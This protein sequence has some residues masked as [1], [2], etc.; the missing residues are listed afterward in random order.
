MIPPWVAGLYFRPRS[1]ER[2]PA[3]RRL[4]YHVPISD[5]SGPS[6]SWY[7]M[8]VLSVL[9][10]LR[11]KWRRKRPGDAWRW[12]KVW[13][14]AYSLAYSILYDHACAEEVADE[15]LLSYAGKL[16]RVRHRGRNRHSYAKR[17]GD[18]GRQTTFRK[19]QLPEHLE[20]AASVFHFS[21]A[22]EERLTDAGVATVVDLDIW[23]IKRT[24]QHVL[25]CSNAF[26]A[27]MGINRGV[28]AYSPVK[29]EVVWSEVVALAPR[30]RE[31]FETGPF[32]KYWRELREA[33]SERFG[34]LISVDHAGDI[35]RRP[36]E[37][38][39]RELAARYVREF[40]MFEGDGPC[41]MESRGWS[42]NE[43]DDAKA[44]ERRFHTFLHPPCYSELIRGVRGGRL[45]PPEKNLGLP[46]YK[47]AMSSNN[48]ETIDRTPAPLSKGQ[49]EQKRADLEGL[50]ELRRVA[51]AD[52][53]VTVDGVER[54]QESAS[55]VRTGRAGFRA[56]ALSQ[57][58]EVWAR[59]EGGGN[60]LLTSCL[61]S[62]SGRR[63]VAELEGGQRVFFHVHYVEGRSGGGA[64]EVNMRYQE[65]RLPR[66]FA[67]AR[68]RRDYS[69]LKRAYR[70][71]RVLI[72]SGVVAVLAVA[73]VVG[74]LL[75]QSGN[76]TPDAAA[77]L[78]NVPAGEAPARAH[79]S[80]EL[81]TPQ[82]GGR[83]DN[84]SG[85]MRSAGGLPDRQEAHVPGDKGSRRPA[86]TPRQEISRA[87]RGPR[88]NVGGARERE[89]K[90]VAPV[91]TIYVE[92]PT[93]FDNADLNL[94]AYEAAVTQLRQ[95]RLFKVVEDPEAAQARLIV[96]S[97]HRSAL[98][99]KVRPQLVTSKGRKL[100]WNGPMIPL[101]DE[102]ETQDARQKAAGVGRSITEAL[103]R[104]KKS[105][106]S[107][108]RP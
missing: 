44:E 89:L 3:G 51:A 108:K 70:S 55:L 1:S 102:E 68:R 66:I 59:R 46:E 97:G 56:P 18:E 31:P 53:V 52:L 63:E 5:S 20:L 103:I 74:S 84:A 86:A 60:I 41:G 71:P 76:R 35:V 80:Q 6:L 33:L 93:V 57:A 82:D 48:R 37:R 39:P 85:R 96:V 26:A 23:Y 90:T 40:T 27:G 25:Q 77:A 69:A 19:I 79:N 49:L 100:I 92:K 62:Q 13:S 16:K 24:I 83:S 98:K 4:R 42:K 12:L 58:V 30:L 95:S 99:E 78:N 73:A 65:T 91:K 22:M 17:A 88:E 29:T 50:L 36:Q 47:K 8:E 87:G 67:L 81:T 107:P 38:Q 101:F 94:D 7:A 54:V 61:L 32:P 2:P 43:S 106:V 104:Q 11:R 75:Y 28:H 45:P 105:E 15:A 10:N 72:P 34:E 14:G 9:Y 64:F 21:R